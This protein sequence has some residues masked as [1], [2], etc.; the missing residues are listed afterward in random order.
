MNTID[1]T[2]MVPVMFLRA[3]FHSFHRGY[4]QRFAISPPNFRGNE[5]QIEW[6]NH[7]PIPKMV[8]VLR[9]LHVRREAFAREA[10]YSTLKSCR[11]TRNIHRHQ[12]M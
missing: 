3:I 10:N 12:R 8:R 6:I 7:F 9:C 5:E 1:D 11:L 4:A 2:V